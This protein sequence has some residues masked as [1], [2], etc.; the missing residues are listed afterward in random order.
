MSI[1]H[2]HEKGDWTCVH[3]L[4]YVQCTGVHVEFMYKDTPH[5]TISR[6]PHAGHVPVLSIYLRVHVHVNCSVHVQTIRSIDLRHSSSSIT[7]IHLYT[8]KWTC[9]E[10]V[11]YHVHRH[12]NAR[13]HVCMYNPETHVYVCMY[14]CTRIP[15]RGRRRTPP[16][17]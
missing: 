6:N 16:H 12:T 10:P 1:V 13:T 5:S 2:V 9:N 14:I 3:L 11:I 15:E 8:Y 17:C 4:V 7:H